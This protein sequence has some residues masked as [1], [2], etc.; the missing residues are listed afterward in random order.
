MIHFKDTVVYGTKEDLKEFEK[1]MVDNGG[2]S[3]RSLSETTI[4]YYRRLL[5]SILLKG[6]FCIS[7]PDQWNLF[8]K[9]KLFNTR[10]NTYFHATRLFLL[11]KFKREG[12]R[13]FDKRLIKPLKR[14]PKKSLVIPDK[15]TKKAIINS[16]S[17][18]K[19]RMIAWI[20]ALT[21]VRAVSALTLRHDDI[22]FDTNKNGDEMITFIF[23]SKGKGRFKD[24]KEI[25]KWIRNKEFINEFN[26]FLSKHY[27]DDE[28]VFLE[29]NLSMVRNRD[30]FAK[31][32]NANY[33]RYYLAIKEAC[34]RFGTN[35]KAF[36]SH[37]FRRDIGRK[38]WEMTRDLMAVKD[39]LDHSDIGTTV[40]YLR[41]SGLQTKEI[42]DKLA[43]EDEN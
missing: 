36:A 22:G 9:D 32:Y 37:D 15:D 25:K 43:D 6:D 12:L 16:I 17:N 38:V 28:F 10:S 31:V 33:H 30:D 24:K 2:Q 20:Q 18:P 19:Y 35:Y 3:G 42:L 5:R 41:Q 40:R 11:Y 26:V 21:G 14:D 39:V 1:F 4:D 34:E 27:Y 23:K 7:S 29:R 13:W 8:L